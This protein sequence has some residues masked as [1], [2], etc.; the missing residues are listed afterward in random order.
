MRG[1]LIAALLATAAWGDFYIV[2]GDEQV[3]MRE[4]T[5][6]KI[7]FSALAQIPAVRKP[8]KGLHARSDTEGFNHKHLNFRTATVNLRQTNVVLTEYSAASERPGSYDIRFGDVEIKEGV[9][10]QLFYHNRWYGAIIGDPLAILHAIFGDVT[11]DPQKAYEAVAAARKAFPDDPVLTGYEKEWKA[12]AYL[13][14]Q[15]ARAE[16]INQTYALYLGTKSPGSK[17]FY[18]AQTRSEIEAFIKEF[19]DS[20]LKPSLDK[21]LKSLE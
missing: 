14:R 18:A 6:G 8:K 11:A 2:N 15:H 5:S 1:F 16:Q 9:M 7:D 13:A 10:L 17:K 3:K 20:P 21:L 12:R 19:P 4:I